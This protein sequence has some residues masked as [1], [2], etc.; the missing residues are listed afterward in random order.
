MSVRVY[1]TQGCAPCHR[2]KQWLRGKN[3]VIEEVELKTAEDFEGSI[4]KYGFKTVPVVE[5]PNGVWNFS[6]G[7]PKLK[8]MLGS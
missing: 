7:L 6:Q 3:V 2:T 4:G 1:W 8:E 5:T